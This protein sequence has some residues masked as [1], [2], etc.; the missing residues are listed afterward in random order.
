MI[1]AMTCVYSYLNSAAKVCSLVKCGDS[2]TTVVKAMFPQSLA[3]ACIVSRIAIMYRS[4]SDFP[5]Y[6]KKIEEYEL[7]F[8]ITVSKNKIHLLF[9]ITLVFVYSIIIIPLNIFRVY[10]IHSYLSDN[11]TSFFYILM[12]VQ[13]LSICS[14]E[15]HFIVRCFG[16]YQKFQLINEV[17]IVV[18]SET[19][20]INKY[21]TVLQNKNRNFFGF[22]GL[23]LNDSD[24]NEDL[25][26]SR[27]NTIPMANN[28]ELLRMR[29]Q[30]VRGTACELN[31]LYG[32]Q[33]GLSLIVLFI[34]A[35][36]DIY[37]EIFTNNN[38]TRSKIL[39]Y[40]WLFQYTLRFCAIIL[41]THITT[42]Q[43]CTYYLYLCQIIYSAKS[44][45]K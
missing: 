5:K 44:K 8:P 17:M 20:I 1:L 28:I 38:K 25:H 6:K 33:L 13:N 27:I 41:I 36:F 16:L 11:S 30:F 4:M 43:V 31:D 26:A 22:L 42:K 7:Y 23:I 29:H 2:V 45:V 14:T 34:M 39:I 9:T 19:I 21:P 15:I 10:L 12:Y 3:I 32:I 24:P 18:K 40:G 35:L 37:G